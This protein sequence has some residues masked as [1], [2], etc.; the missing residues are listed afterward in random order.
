MS[1]QLNAKGYKEQG[2][3]PFSKIKVNFG[4]YHNRPSEKVSS[5]IMGW[6]HLRYQTIHSNYRN[7]LIC[8]FN[9]YLNENLNE[10][11]LYLIIKCIAVQN[12]NHPLDHFTYME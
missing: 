7:K 3:N 5:P 1:S 2:F 10:A 9:D 11:R 4:S 6:Y 12:K 8:R